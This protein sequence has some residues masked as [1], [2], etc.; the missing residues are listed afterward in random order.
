[1]HTFKGA[2]LSL[3]ERFPCFMLIF[4]IH[5]PDSLVRWV[6]SNPPLTAEGTQGHG[7]PQQLAQNPQQYETE[8]ALHPSCLTI[9]PS[10]CNLFLLPRANF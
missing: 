10:L 7:G 4:L 1:M 8:P 6:R 3:L 5:F 2:L 9:E